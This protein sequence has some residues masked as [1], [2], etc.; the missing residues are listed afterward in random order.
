MI[1]ENSHIVNMFITVIE[2]NLVPYFILI[3]ILLYIYIY[4][5][6][7]SDFCHNSRITPYVVRI[8][9][10]GKDDVWQIVQGTK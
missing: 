3:R 8:A 9:D 10:I 1:I 2:I 5:V 4:I 6:F 7:S